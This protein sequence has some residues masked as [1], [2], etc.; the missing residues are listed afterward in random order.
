MHLDKFIFYDRVTALGLWDATCW[1]MVLSSAL[2]GTT[3]DQLIMILN[4]S[5]CSS[6]LGLLMGTVIV[7]ADFEF[8]NG[9]IDLYFQRD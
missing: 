1:F 3:V 2:L 5:Y 7:L 4:S 9:N 6:L 8:K